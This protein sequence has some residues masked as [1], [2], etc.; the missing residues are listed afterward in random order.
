MA[1][2]RVEI[3]EDLCKGCSLCISACPKGVLVIATDR[4]NA[5]G[6]HPVQLVDPNGECTGCALCAVMCP[7][8]VITVF[9]E[10]PATSRQTARSEV[11]L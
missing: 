11:A 8:I 10:V 2:G 9:R 1:K 4:L 7:D 6:Y 5:K 3:R